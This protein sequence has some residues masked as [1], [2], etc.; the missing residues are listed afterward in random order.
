[1]SKKLTA[2]VLVV[3]L[4]CSIFSVPANAA[5]GYTEPGSDRMTNNWANPVKCHVVAGPGSDTT[6]LYSVLEGKKQSLAVDVFA[7]SGKRKSHKSIA[8]P[9]TAWGGTVYRASDGCTY[10]ITGNEGETAFFVLKFSAG[11]DLLGTCAI[12][13][14]ESYTREAFEGG[15]SDI[16][17][18]DRYLIVHAARGRKDGHQS[19]TTFFIDSLTMKPLYISEAFGFSHVSHSFNQFV[20]CDGDRVIMIDHG[21]GY[22]RGVYMQSFRADI[23]EGELTAVDRCAAE[24]F[25]FKG[26]QG[27]NY[28]GATVDGFEIGR[29][30]N[31]VV[32]TSIPHDQ[33]SSDEAFGAY[34]GCNNIFAVVVDKSL[35]SSQLKW[36]TAYEDTV[37]VRNLK[38]I[39]LS[40]EQFVLVYGIEKDGEAVST[41]YRIVDS[42]GNVQKSG[43]VEKP[44][45]CTSEP[46]FD[47]GKLVWCHY[48][49][50][51][52]GHFLVRHCWNT[53]SGE[54]TVENLE[55]GLSSAVSEISSPYDYARRTYTVGQQT[56]LQVQ[57]YST[58]FAKD[59]PTAPAVW[60][61]S[62]PDVV[63]VLEPESILSSAVTNRQYKRTETTIKTKRAGTATVTCSVGD[64]IW[65]A[66]LKIGGG[67][68]SA[69]QTGKVTSIKLSGISKKLAAGKKVQL[70]A[71]VK[72]ENAANKTL[73]WS[74]SN[75]KYATVDD[76]GKVAL[77]KGGADKTVTITAKAM[78]GSRKKGTYKITI[79]K[80]AV[81]SVKIKKAPGSLRSGKSVTLKAQVKT[82]GKKANKGLKWKSSKSKYAKV[83]QKGVV[84]ALKAGKGKIVTI[85]AMATDGSGKKGSVKI[86]IK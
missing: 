33:F 3:C 71:A 75:K 1:M 21:D 55:A 73:S 65:S 47:N 51:S 15:N 42:Q 82:T 86:K 29:E 22:P 2:W 68:S 64:K 6:V 44:F 5:G 36:L 41:A 61:S 11:W 48:V 28:T 81:K 50:S 54:Y 74:S 32:G 10:V 76:S 31:L 57:V 46:D 43:E 16:V 30:A 80:D 4:W 25:S 72:P 45:Y 58:V 79:M 52:L 83:S 77:K 70:S 66:R 34:K 85:T 84:K 67:Q 8:V 12:G 9:G 20:R 7:E 56:G 35:Q 27:N 14:D 38:M 13:K 60:K 69:D 59:Y 39:R 78:D 18:V 53:D 40:E 49:E 23:A 24:L 19:N 62:N 63:E 37:R 17:L 26:A